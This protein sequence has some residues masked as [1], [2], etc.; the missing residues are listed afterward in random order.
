MNLSHQF[1]LLNI[2]KLVFSVTGF[3]LFTASTRAG[4]VSSNFQIV[5]DW[6]LR[7]SGS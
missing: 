5:D 1:P 4:I 3:K 7:W 6:I 2:Q